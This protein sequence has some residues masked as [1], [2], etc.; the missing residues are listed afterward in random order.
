MTTGPDN[1]YGAPDPGTPPTHQPY[2]A[3]PPPPPP[4]GAPQQQY[5]QQPGYGQPYGQPAYG[6]PPYPYAVTPPT[7]GLA[8]GAMITGIAAFV[9]ACLYGIGLLASPVALVLGR[10]SMNRIKRS[11]GRLGGRGFAV[12]GFVLGII[13][14]VL[15]VIVVAVVVILIVVYVND[16]HAFDDSGSGTVSG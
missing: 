16:P 6:Q 2:G 11:E 5:P 7:D 15:L 13:G 14:T 12:A 9:L 10:V 8:L 4:Y 3:P 1:P